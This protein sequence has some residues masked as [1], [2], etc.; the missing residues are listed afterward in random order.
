[1]LDQIINSSLPQ[2]LI[3]LIVSA[4]PVAELR[5]SLPLAVKIFHMAW[6]QSFLLSVA[7]NMIPVPFLLLFLDSLAGLVSRANSGKRFM[8]WVYARTRR[9][10]GFIDKYGHIGLIV[11]VAI[12][13]P[14]TGAWTASVA[15]HLLGMKFKH[16][17]LDITLGVVGA[18]AIV[19]A[20]VL[21][22]WI[23]AGV[24]VVGLAVMVATHIWRRSFFLNHKS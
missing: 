9:Q 6:Y 23:G 20:L 13:L 18:G 12:P 1:M 14:G 19:T 21:S 17:L 4:L 2:Q 24:A 7:G 3:V 8:E 16:A 22:G 15:A 11:F 10:T 5:G